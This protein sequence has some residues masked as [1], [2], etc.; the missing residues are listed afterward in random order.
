MK[1][2][3]HRKKLMFRWITKNHEFVVGFQKASHGKCSKCGKII[4]WGNLC[5]E[6]FDKSKKISKK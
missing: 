4:R 1:H 5:N 2:R 6:C 3:V